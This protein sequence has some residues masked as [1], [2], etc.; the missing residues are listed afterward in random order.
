MKCTLCDKDYQIHSDT[1]YLKLPTFRCNNCDLIVTGNNELEIK[2]QTEKIYK[3]KHW[4]DGNLWDAE[5]SIDSNYTDEESLGKK[6]SWISQ[7][8]YCNPYLKN[9][10]TIFEIGSG[11]GQASWWFEQEGFIVTGIEPDSK[12]VELINLKLKKGKCIVGSGED[13]EINEKFDVIWMSHVLEH[14]VNPD[15]FFSKIKNNMKNDGIFF[16]EVPNCENISVLKTSIE[17]VPHT[18]HFSKKSLEKLA[19]KNLF[20]VIKSDYFRPASKLE[21]IK[22][23]TLKKYPYYPRIKCKNSDGLYLRMILRLSEK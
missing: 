23:K 9:K 12:N 19:K 14:L 16:I 20:Q 11:Q 13:F 2:S 22:Q 7:Y 1:S 4:G 15:Y 6:R 10:K 5:R 3:Q 17:L 18:F 8:K 21:G